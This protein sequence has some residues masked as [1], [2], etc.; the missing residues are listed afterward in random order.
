MDR[1]TYP[2]QYDNMAPTAREMS[3]EEAALA[4]AESASAYA[5]V[6]SEFAK[7]ST[8]FMDVRQRLNAAYE[9]LGERQSGL[10]SARERQGA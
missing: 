7:I 2:T 8:Q 9:N 4:V 10:A 5:A 6:C 3:V 1:P